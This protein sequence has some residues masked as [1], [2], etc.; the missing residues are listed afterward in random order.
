MRNKRGDCY[1]IA[2]QFAMDNIFTP[3]KIDYKG[4]PYLVHAEVQGQGKVSNLRYGH[5]WIED[6]ENVYDFSNDRELIIP[7][8][9]YYAIGD[10]KT[11][12]PKKYQKYTF[13][14]A[15]R[16]MVQTR[17]YGCWDLDV[18]YK[19]GGEILLAPNGKSSNLTPEQYR[20]VRTP[21]FISWFGDW[22]DN[23]NE[24]MLL[25]NGEPMILWR[26]DSNYE[27]VSRD[28]PFYIYD[29]SKTNSRRFFFSPSQEYAE[30]RGYFARP[31]FIK[32]D[33]IYRVKDVDLRHNFLPADKDKN[34]ILITPGVASEHDEYIAFYPNQIKIADGTNT[35]FDGSNPD[36]RYA[37][38][39]GV[40]NIIVT[41]QYREF[42]PEVFNELDDE[43]I[44]GLLIKDETKEIGIVK[45]EED[46]LDSGVGYIFGIEVFDRNLGYGRK[47]INKIF[48][49]H[50]TQIAFG[51]KATR[52][53]KDFWIKLGAD[54][55]DDSY[56]FILERNSKYK[57][58]GEIQ[59]HKETYKKWKSLVN[60][61]KT[62]LEKFYN[63]QE[64]KDAGLSSSEASSQGISSGR[65]SARWIMRM[66]DTPVSEW[67]P[68]M[69]R[70]ANKQIS[71][72]SRMSGNKGPLYDEKG[73]KT[74]KH[75][76][77]LIWG[78][79]P[80]KYELGG[81]F[82]GS[83]NDFCDTGF[84]TKKVGSSFKKGA[85]GWGIYFSNE[86]DVAKRYSVIPAE[87]QSISYEK[88]KELVR[89][90][91][92]AIGTKYVESK[93]GNLELILNTAKREEDVT[94][95]FKWYKEVDLPYI[96]RVSLHKG[97]TP[98]QYDYAEFI[99]TEIQI[100]K[101]KKQALKENIVLP[102]LKYYGKADNLSTAYNFLSDKL[103]GDK[104][105]SLFFLRAG[106]DGIKYPCYF[107]DYINIKHRENCYNYV[108]FD[109]SNVSIEECDVVEKIELLQHSVVNDFQ[110]GSSL[111]FYQDLIFVIGDDAKD[112]V[113]LYKDF[114]E[115]KR[116][117][118]FQSETARIP[119]DVKYDLETSTIVGINGVNNLLILGSGAKQEFRSVGYLIPLN[120][121]Y[122]VP[123][124]FRYNTFVSRL[125]KE[126]GI[127]EINIEGC[128]SLPNNFL[129]ANRGNKTN[130]DNLLI[131]TEN[132]FWENQ[133]NATISVCRMLLPDKDAAVSELNY[134]ERTDTLFFTASIEHTTNAI[135][136]G[137]IGDSFLG[138]IKNIS[139]KLNHNTIQIDEF[140]NLSEVSS[141]FIGHKI[142]GMCIENKSG[143]SYTINLVSD[144]DNDESTIFKIVIK[145]NK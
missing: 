61:S 129:L 36:I 26:G 22:E 98:D 76:S 10:I 102:D 29:L 42:D 107:T 5:A 80:K 41:N 14:E 118:M 1:Y 77:L 133:E 52:S 2:G 95:D 59:E 56:D 86:E 138:Y 126:D 113:V 24:N 141:K 60:M 144:N 81:L 75:T 17:N 108:V 73:R 84:D 136:D 66:K 18:E 69:W 123:E 132:N 121:K 7:K 143:N 128:A 124:P 50:P 4:T 58:G 99:L 105:A 112:V 48:E 93:Y 127:K 8:V 62:E 115:A 71:F 63:S 53:S 28:T 120:T 32:S 34:P 109:S 27:S 39:G 91:E 3:K 44:S 11:D 104:E 101:L 117:N 116:V 85:M 67:T 89:N 94:N 114:T 82:H 72:I 100:L 70:W 140:H 40:G 88:A 87:K 23:A 130:P 13:A 131:V 25:E 43:I 97:K 96:Y 20:L 19:N 103:N 46:I 137:N 110:S 135:D 90:G 12:N 38:G 125:K 145:I 111:D 21:A 31:F 47:I 6:D 78:H 54:F 122:V 64:G 134:D 74:R 79:N 15:R 33:M 37:D 55:N 16:K 35:T 92:K 51:G 65:E 30:S 119:K 68:S 49:I 106:I 142:E 83:P 139:Q 9:V 45:A 57:A